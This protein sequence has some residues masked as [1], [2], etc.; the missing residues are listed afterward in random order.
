MER[1][2]L[3]SAIFLVTLSAHAEPCKVVSVS[4]GDTLTVHC[5][6]QPQEKVRIAGIDAPERGQAYENRS[7][8]SLTELCAGKEARVDRQGTDRYK[9][10]IARVY[11]K[12]NHFYQDA[13][14]EQLIKGM[15]WAYRDHSPGTA[16]LNVEAHARSNKIGLWAD[17]NPVPPWEWRK[18]D[19]AN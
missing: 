14:S 13:S 18:S 11:C 16:L 19:K 7:R 2:L 1:L 3:F 6:E 17:A 5:S 9:R 15:A 12:V 4:D 10:T 8:E